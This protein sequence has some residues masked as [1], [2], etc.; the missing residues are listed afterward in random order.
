MERK[1]KLSIPKWQWDLGR[2]KKDPE[3][4]FFLLTAFWFTLVVLGGFS[5][6]FYFKESLS[7][8]RSFIK[9][10]GVVY[11]IWTLFYFIQC[12]MVASKNVQWHMF[13]GNLTLLLLIL[14]FLTGYYTILKSAELRANDVKGGTLIEIA[15]GVSL[16][17][18]AIAKRKNDYQHKRLMLAA[19]T[20]LT[21]AAVQR[22]AR[23]Y[24]NFDDNF[25]LIAGLYFAPLVA[26][27]IFDQL[28]F[29]KIRYFSLI[30]LALLIFNYFANPHDFIFSTSFG[31]SLI[32]I[33]Q[34]LF[35]W[36]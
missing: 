7:P 14:L 18:L 34:R 3:K 36:V 5:D 10:H 8:T 22:L 29:K 27:V 31:K 35:L 11:S 21:S 24:W 15:I 6:S 30:L 26:L 33:L 13:I 17:F 12:L 20:A 2:L 1:V 25:W 16:A 32:E 4:Q 19:M 23:T 28:Y 9:V